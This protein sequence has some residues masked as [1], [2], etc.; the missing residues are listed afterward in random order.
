MREYSQFKQNK[1]NEQIYL[2]SIIWNNTKLSQLNIQ[3]TCL[4]TYNVSSP[5]SNYC[6]GFVI[7]IMNLHDT[8]LVIAS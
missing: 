2:S 4:S 5:M 6:D 7:D 8:L 1:R 3:R